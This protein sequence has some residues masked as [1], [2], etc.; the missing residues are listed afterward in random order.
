MNGW[1]PYET[2]TDPPNSDGNSQ[3]LDI[4]ASS[5]TMRHSPPA[6]T[7]QPSAGIVRR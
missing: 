5:N 7:P 3:H 6:S 2:A 1:L 4:A